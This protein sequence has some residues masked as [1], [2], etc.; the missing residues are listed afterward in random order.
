MLL[1]YNMDGKA[2]FQSK[3]SRINDLFEVDIT[4][5]HDGIYMLKIGADNDNS[6]LIKLIKN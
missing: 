2:V 1:F 5:Q 3:I 4:N 6:S